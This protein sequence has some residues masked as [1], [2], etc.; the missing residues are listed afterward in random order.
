[1]LDTSNLN[2]VAKIIIE[3][4]EEAGFDE[5][6]IYSKIDRLESFGDNQWQTFRWAS[7]QLDGKNKAIFS[8][9]IGVDVVMLMTAFQVIEAVDDK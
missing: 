7:S 8:E 1:M 4:F 3:C 5:P 2:K 6:Y 9:K